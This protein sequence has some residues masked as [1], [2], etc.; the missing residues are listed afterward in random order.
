MPSPFT[1]IAIIGSGAVGTY[2]GARLGLAGADVRFLMRGDLAAVRRRNSIVVRDRAGTAELRPVTA[3]ASA[4]EIGPVDLAVVCLKTTSSG[5]LPGLLTP[6]LGAGTAILTLQNGL[7]AD[8]F[9]AGKF[10]AGRVIGGLVF[11]AINRTGPGEATCY[12]PGMI[13]IGE[14]EGAAKPRTEA[15]AGLLRSAGMKTEV[16]GRLLE[17]RWSKL[18]WNIPF[19]GL[20]IAEAV[21]TDRICSDPRLAAEA[22]ALMLEVQAA[23]ARFGVEIPDAF[24]QK[25]FDVTPPMGAYRPSSLVDYLAG[26]DVE[27]EAIWGEPLRRAQAAGAQ[28]PRLAALHARLVEACARKPVP[29]IPG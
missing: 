25:Q 18:V 6:V 7:G 13:R 16:V 27:V 10:G 19:N 3:F 4:A 8:E 5:D 28:V 2:Y 29:L 22:R 24:V 26:R 15:L 11:M 1:R 20:S 17:A 23:A 12:H 9:L 21:T 14:F